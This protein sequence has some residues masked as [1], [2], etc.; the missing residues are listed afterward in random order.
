MKR[1]E[2]EKK[3]INQPITKFQ[4]EVASDSYHDRGETRQYASLE[5]FNRRTKTQHE[6][7]S[8]D[9]AM[10]V[11]MESLSRFQSSLLCLLFRDW[12]FV[13]SIL[14][15]VMQAAACMQPGGPCS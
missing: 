6:S 15:L 13:C 4:R 11:Y 3:R 7:I 5:L 10:M 1:E 14:G 12:M 9:I 8:T 2:Q